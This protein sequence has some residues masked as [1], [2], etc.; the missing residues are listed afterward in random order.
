MSRK[1]TIKI[2]QYFTFK[3]FEDAYLK[4]EFYKKVQWEESSKEYRFDLTGVKWVDLMELM[5]LP[6]SSDYIYQKTKCKSEFEFYNPR[7]Y[8]KRRDRKELIEVFDFIKNM[9]FPDLLL[10]KQLKIRSH[11]ESLPTQD[12]RR[13]LPITILHPDQFIDVYEEIRD[14]LDFYYGEWLKEVQIYSF[15]DRLVFEACENIFEHAYMNTEQEIHTSRFIA[16]R[17]YGA[18]KDF[19]AILKR[20]KHAVPWIKRIQALYP[21]TDILEIVVA[22]GGDGIY[23]TLGKRHQEEVTKSIREKDSREPTPLELS[24]ISCIRW[25]LSTQRSTSST[26]KLSK[27]KKGYGLFL[28]K[29]YCVK[30]WDGCFFIRS[31]RSRVIYIN[32]VDVPWAMNDKLEFFPG[33]QIRMFLP[34]V[35]K[36]EELE[37]VKKLDDRL[38]EE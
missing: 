3:N 29:M 35:N 13:L 5:C 10:S 27:A 31:G 21:E 36:I 2:P 15:V 28:M 11:I 23:R 32:D 12:E 6:I 37:E 14:K 17:K 25:A 8:R 20:T 30:G 9:H 18:A 34:I 16:I 33:V 22:D 4:K 1:I 24:E 7:E 19:D 26:L 38:G